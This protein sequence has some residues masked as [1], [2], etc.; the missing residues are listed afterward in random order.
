M[1]SFY[2]LF[3]FFLSHQTN[4]ESKNIRR[5]IPNKNVKSSVKVYP[6]IHEWFLSWLACHSIFDNFNILIFVFPD[7]R[8]AIIPKYHPQQ[9]RHQRSLL[10]RP[11]QV[12]SLWHHESWVIWC[13][14]DMMAWWQPGDWCADLD[15]DWRHRLQHPA[16]LRWALPQLVQRWRLDVKTNEW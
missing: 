14:D 13:H 6:S 8:E 11:L 1:L 2:P 12:T 16:V 10:L 4:S 15:H 9:P 3:I 5:R 7:S